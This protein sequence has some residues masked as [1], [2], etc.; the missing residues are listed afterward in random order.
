MPASIDNPMLGYAAFAGV[1]WVGYTLAAALINKCW[2]VKP[3]IYKIGTA[4]LLIGMVFGVGVW[5]FTILGASADDTLFI[6]SYFLLLMPVRLL[7][8]HLLFRWFYQQPYAQAT[9]WFWLLGGC[10]WSYVLDFPAALGWFATA[11]F[12][13]C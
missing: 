2:G 1:K 9:K 7:E 5:G 10:A 8:W 13:V 3:S 12:W 6:F 4:R 11:G